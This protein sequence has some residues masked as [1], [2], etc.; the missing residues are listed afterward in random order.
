MKWVGRILLVIAASTWVSVPVAAQDGAT[1]V[2]LGPD[3]IYDSASLLQDTTVEAE[4][5]LQIEPELKNVKLAM[6]YSLLLPGLGESYLGH[7]GRATVFFVA[8]GAIWTSFAVFRIQGNHREELYKE[9]AEVHAGVAQRDDEDFY[10]TIGNFIA[11]DG[12]FSA[13]EQV[14][15]QA[16]SIHPDDREAQDEYFEENAYTG[17]DAWRWLSEDRLERYGEMRGSAQNAY[18][19]S[20]LAVGLLVANR[21]LSVVDVGLLGA[22]S[23][24]E[25]AD[26]QARLSWNFEAPQGGPGARITLSRT[27]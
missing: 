13:N 16:R 4:P 21:I 25:Q 6:L 17:D 7:K 20:E 14:R 27:F 5:D 2:H 3:R 8:E 26:D 24:R 11:A 18:H 10:R 1:R 23:K 22:R 15:R 19:N 12:P 9:F